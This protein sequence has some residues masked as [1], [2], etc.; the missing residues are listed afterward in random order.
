M[1]V[2][3]LNAHKCNYENGLLC[4]F[5]LRILFYVN[6][7]LIFN[8]T[9]N[10]KL[11]SNCLIEL[12]ISTTNYNRVGYFSACVITPSITLITKIDF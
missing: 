6:Y 3:L 2:T 12:L 4:L 8:K 1:R 9:I 7:F 11:H 10:L 5:V